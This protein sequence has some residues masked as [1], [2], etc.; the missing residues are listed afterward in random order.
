MHYGIFIEN[1]PDLH[2]HLLTPFAFCIICRQCMSPI[3]WC[4]GTI[5]FE[6]LCCFVSFMVPLHHN[7]IIMCCCLHMYPAPMRQQYIGYKKTRVNGIALKCV[8]LLVLDCTLA[9]IYLFYLLA[10]LKVLFMYMPMYVTNQY[11]YAHNFHDVN[12]PNIS[13]S[14][15][16]LLQLD[17]NWVVTILAP[18]VFS[19]IKLLV[20]EDTYYSLQEK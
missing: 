20:L 1:M 14:N 6:S 8:M 12:Q 18:I 16:A 4:C 10:V 15:N 17:Q 7:V 2:C 13:I 9:F 5:S 3:C 19:P 11:A